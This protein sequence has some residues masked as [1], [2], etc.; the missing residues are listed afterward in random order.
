MLNALASRRAASDR[1]PHLRTVLS[2]DGTVLDVLGEL[3]VASVRQ[4]DAAIQLLVTGSRTRIAVRMAD[5]SFIDS[6]GLGALLRA[7][8]VASAH[9]LTFTILEPSA[10][11]RRLLALTALDATLCLEAPAG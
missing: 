4:F 5:V 9:G 10:R 6:S 7:H 3:D 1:A 8:R 11:V 2:D